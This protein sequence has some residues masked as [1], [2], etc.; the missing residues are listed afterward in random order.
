M[1]NRRP[2]NFIN[3][4]N[5]FLGTQNLPRLNQR[6]I[7]IQMEHTVDYI[8]IISHTYVPWTIIQP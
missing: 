8:Y 2:T 3:Y 6:D 4:M 1:N 5:K 7:G